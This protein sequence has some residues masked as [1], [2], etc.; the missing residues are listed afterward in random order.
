MASEH[1]ERL[2]HME[3]LLPEEVSAPRRAGL[4]RAGM[5][6]VY[7]ALARGK[8]TR[9]PRL[10]RILSSVIGESANVSLRIRCHR[11]PIFFF[12]SL[13]PLNPCFGCLRRYPTLDETVGN[14]V[15]AIFYDILRYLP[16]K[17]DP[18][19]PL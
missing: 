16:I 3:Q 18:A 14:I 15:A 7:T 17:Y 13:A 6:E 1:V 9:R 19:E 11:T 5:I 8:A 4:L 10:A 2:L 12:V